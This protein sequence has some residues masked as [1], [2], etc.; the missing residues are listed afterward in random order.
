MTTWR[1]TYRWYGQQ[2]ADYQEDV[3]AGCRDR[4]LM[5]FG[6]QW[7]DRAAPDVLVSVVELDASG[8]EIYP[9]AP[10][11]T[12]AP[13]ALLDAYLDEHPDCALADPARLIRGDRHL[14][15]QVRARAPLTGAH[16]MLLASHT[17]TQPSYWEGAERLYRADL[18][19]GRTDV[20]GG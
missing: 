20:T 10:D 6:N 4:A 9:F 18:A 5:E 14:L 7:T 19:A 17:G 2:Q 8:Q 12:L 3:T 15:G 13:V 11:W 1:I 16:C